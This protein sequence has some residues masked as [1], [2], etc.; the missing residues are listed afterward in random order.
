[1][2][3]FVCLAASRFATTLGCL[4][5]AAAGFAAA[6]VL[7]GGLSA[8]ARA[9]LDTASLNELTQLARA[10]APQLAL[11]RMD[12]E[13]PAPDKD[14]AA[15]SAWEQERLQILANQGLYAAL[16]ERVAGLP[17][18]V[19][20][21]FRR[22]ALTLKADAQLQ[23]NRAEAAR[24]TLRELLWADTGAQALERARWRQLVI[25]SYVLEDRSEDARLALLRYRQDY[26]DEQPQMRW[27]N[28]QVMLQSGHAE[29]AYKLLKD[30]NSPQGSLLRYSAELQVAPQEAGKVAEAAVKMAQQVEA[31]TLQGAFW[32]LAAQAA[33]D[34]RQPLKRIEYLEHALALPVNRQLIHGVISYINASVTTN[35]NC[36]ATTR[37]GISPRPTPLKRT[38]CAPAS[39][40]ACLPSTAAAPSAVPSLTG[41]WSACWT[42]CPTANS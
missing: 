15:W 11:K 5:T 16:L 19:D 4:R 24:A 25:R 39:C 42:I 14:M 38:R 13:Q 32:G 33:G 3:V 9:D 7:V 29:S 12:A 37:T 1:L 8:A 2:P 18:A 40:S 26:G 34:S 23:L 10:G 17:A 41:T 21:E 35:R 27:L 30:D 22:F 31:T 6:L 36:S 20:P 28:A